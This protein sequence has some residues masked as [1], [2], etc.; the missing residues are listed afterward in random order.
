MIKIRELR[1][2]LGL[3][4]GFQ[5]QRQPLVPVCAGSRWRCRVRYRVMDD[6]VLVDTYAVGSTGSWC[7]LLDT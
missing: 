6:G 3:G 7:M 4:S 5:A 1:S 2:R